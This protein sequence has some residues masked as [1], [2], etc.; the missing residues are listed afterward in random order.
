MKYRRS[1]FFVFLIAIIAIVPFVRRD[2]ASAQQDSTVPGQTVPTTASAARSLYMPLIVTGRLSSNPPPTPTPGFTE[3]MFMTKSKAQMARMGISLGQVRIFLSEHTPAQKEA[4][5]K[6]LVKSWDLT[7]GAYERFRQTDPNA[8]SPFRP[9]VPTLTLLSNPNMQGGSVT[10]IYDNQRN[11]EEIVV[12]LG[13]TLSTGQLQHTAVNE[14]WPVIADTEAF[15]SVDQVLELPFSEGVS[16]VMSRYVLRHSAEGQD[17]ESKFVPDQAGSELAQTIID[18][19]WGQDIPIG[20][21][22]SR[23]DAATRLN[24]K[25]AAGVLAV[26]QRSSN[27]YMLIE[28]LGAIWSKKAVET[29]SAAHPNDDQVLIAEAMSFIAWQNSGHS[30]TP[31]GVNEWISTQNALM[32]DKIIAPVQAKLSN[33][34]VDYPY[35][36]VGMNSRLTAPID[37]NGQK[38]YGRMVEPTAFFSSTTQTDVIVKFFPDKDVVGGDYALPRNILFTRAD[39]STVDI[40]LDSSEI[41]YVLHPLQN[42]IAVHISDTATSGRSG[43]GS[44]YTIGIDFDWEGQ[45]LDVKRYVERTVRVNVSTAA[46][47]AG[48]SSEEPFPLTKRREIQAEGVGNMTEQQLLELLN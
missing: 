35:M 38:V 2:F 5:L 31:V 11:L 12:Q 22:D 45:G 1:W 4:I 19:H 47:A 21:L 32:R 41:H 30:Y 24:D 17:Q 27:M 20:D 8:P 13:T 9:T 39:G 29:F 44:T 40:P 33:L 36:I 10:Y 48:T 25:Q 6:C 16:N 23:D 26:L 42:V 28:H 46:S 18:T 3:E 15:K 43:D 34:Q 7:A 37:V 14:S